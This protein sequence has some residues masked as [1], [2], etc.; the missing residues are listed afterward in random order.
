MFDVLMVEDNPADVLLMEL[1]LEDF[2]PELTLHVVADGVEALA[3]LNRHAPYE[4]TLRPK[5]V[6]LD[7][8]TPRMDAVDVLTALRQDNAFKDLPVLMFTGSA[9]E[10]DMQKCLEA[11]ATDYITKPM[12]V[13]AYTEVV[14]RTLGFWAARMGS[15]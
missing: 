15:A 7:G 2:L 5:L 3:F 9:A 8:N 11:G 6:L 12:G 4:R 13:E 1:A 10:A 14:H